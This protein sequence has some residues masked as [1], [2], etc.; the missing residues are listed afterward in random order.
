MALR[1]TLA[2]LWR[3]V[4][5]SAYQ[6]TP[7]TPVFD[8]TPHGERFERPTTA[9][10]AVRV[11]PHFDQFWAEVRERDPR[12]YAAWRSAFETWRSAGLGTSMPR[13]EDYAT[14]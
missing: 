6:S 5:W 9:A 13:P 10:E 4:Q 12:G 7:G 2:T 3:N 1:Q 14:H 11:R 8:Y